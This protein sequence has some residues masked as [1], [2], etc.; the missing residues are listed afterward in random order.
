MV[1]SEQEKFVREF[2]FV[3]EE[4]G[5]GFDALFSSVH[6]VSEEQVAGLRWKPAHLKQPEKIRV[7]AMDITCEQKQ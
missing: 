5:Y 3:R 1:A 4:K 2:D 6:I 7:L